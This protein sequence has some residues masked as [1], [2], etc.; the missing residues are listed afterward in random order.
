MRVVEFLG[1]EV[2]VILFAI[3]FVLTWVKKNRPR[4]KIRKAYFS[5]GP[6]D[7]VERK[8]LN[9]PVV[10]TYYV[11]K[12]QYAVY[13]DTGMGVYQFDDYLHRDALEL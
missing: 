3:G 10:Y 13:K 5:G 1:I 7:G 6:L 12:G 4:N 11:G 9:P 8:M 2:I